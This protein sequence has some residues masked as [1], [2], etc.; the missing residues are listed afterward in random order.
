MRQL[1][2][3][4]ALIALVAACGRDD[5]PEAPDATQ[6]KADRPEGAQMSEGSEEQADADAQAEAEAEAE[7]KAQAQA[8]AE[9]EAED[10]Q[11]RLDKFA[12]VEMVPDIA[13][14]N[15]EEIEVVNLLIDAA[16]LMTEIYIRQVSEESPEL[17]EAIA[18]GDNPNQSKLLALYDLHLGVWDGLDE[19]HPFYGGEELPEGAAFYP[20]DMTV[21]EFESWIAD[22]PEDREAFTSPYTVIRR[23]EAGELTAIPYSEYYAEWLEPAAQKLEEAAELTSNASLKDYLNKRAAAF[24][25]N[26]YFESDMAWMDLAGTPIEIVIGPYEVYTDR[27]LGQKAAFEAFVT[28]KNPEESEALAK[29]KDYLPDM[30][31]N[32]PVGDKYK[33]F[34]RGFE[35]PIVVAEQVHGGGDNVP[36]VQTLAFNLPND[37]R[38]REAKGAKKVILENVLDAKH[39]MI[40]MPMAEK[41]LIENQANMVSG[42]Y[43]RLNTLFHELSHSMGPGTIIVDGRE[44][45][46]NAE[47]KDQYS[48]L[49]EGKA[50]V[51]GIYNILYMMEEGEIFSDERDELFSTYVA[52]LFRSMRFGVEEAH[53]RGAAMQ[54]GYL[55]DAGAVEW[56]PQEERFQINYGVMENA[57]S[58]LVAEI[59]RLQGDGDYEGTKAFMEQY[60]VLDAPARQVIDSTGGIPVDMQPNYPEQIGEG[61]GAMIPKE[62]SQPG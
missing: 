41:V 57:V 23:G 61:A 50:D 32:L 39:E 54:Y 1:L 42:K 17:R 58:G 18:S 56:N 55:I 33:N 21:E 4:A 35:S 11:A 16:N 40:L 7:A 38:V 37:E 53:G 51:M 27:L 8:Q 6:A 26:D 60:A 45:T 59:V 44:T 30:E 36:G 22:H 3:S 31:R 46:V 47:L 10:L 48:A 2:F 5:A 34:E 52:G 12:T 13:F 28:L 20:E 25:S 43:M 24:R 29:Y 15:E 49:E 19:F 9:A 14:L 62:T